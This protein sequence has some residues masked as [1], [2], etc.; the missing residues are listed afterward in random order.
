MLDE[1]VYQFF[2]GVLL[3]RDPVE[4]RVPG[5][6][7]PGFDMDEGRRHVNEFGPKLHV[8]FH[9]L[10]NIVEILR[11]DGSDGNVVDID[12]LLAD[13]VEQQVKR[14]LVM[15]QAYVQR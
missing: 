6:K 15:L 10:L 14:T 12:L 3:G 9:R 1:P 7:R 13:K 11:R 8:E 2:P 4:F 5:K